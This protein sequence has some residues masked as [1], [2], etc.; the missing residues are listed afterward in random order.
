MNDNKKIAVNSVI[1]FIRL[2]VTTV[3][4]ILASRYVLDALG[5]SDYGLYNVVGGIVVLLNVFNTAM[6]ST[7]YTFI[8]KALGKG[9]ED[10]LN[11]VF[12]TSLVIHL[13][14][15]IIIVVLGLT[16]GNWYIDNYLN[17]PEGKLPD[18][19]FVFYFSIITTSISTLLIPY[20]GLITAHEKF[21]VLAVRDIVMR[22]LYFVAVITILYTDS[23]RIRM[24]AW[25]Q[26]TYNLIYNGS[27][28]IYCKQKFKNQITL[29]I[30]KD[31]S[32]LKEMLS[33]ASWTLVGAVANVAKGQGCSI[34]L[35]FFFGT[36][37][38]A[39]YAVAN[40]I[41]NF[42]LTF[43]RSLNNA[44]IPQ[45]TKSFSGGDQK[46]SITLTSYISK[47][48]F[49]LMSLVAFPVM[50]E[51][52]FLLG[53]WLKEVPEGSSV[54]CKLMVLTGLLNCLGE[55]IPAM[56][57]AT[58]KIRGYQLVVNTILL[59]GLPIGYLAYKL[60]ADYYAISVVYCIIFGFIGFVKLYMLHRVVDFN[61]KDF[62]QISYSKILY[63]SIPLIVAYIFYNSSAF[64]I[65][66]HILGL[67][68]SELFLMIDIAI[69]GLDSKERNIVLSFF[70]KKFN[71]I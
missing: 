15:A 8:A 11:V 64:S 4:G 59:S 39:A 67:I 60:G 50:M 61:V 35:N 55:G 18:A 41:E 34:V 31:T 1:I 10:R 43:A 58:G 5:A 12:N 29:K 13:C 23:S 28:F 14:F 40:Q 66:G 48:T 22:V 37:V 21:G 52:D 53:L 16:V 44:A 6:V 57:N 47:Y 42:I 20:Q 69:L 30:T 2:V 46:R 49:L 51:M 25:I 9:E 65:W 71:R 63:V 26:L 27:F 33:F 24:Y 45:I 62:F 7:T 17:V 19:H 70:K 68:L 38:N 56:V 3:L 54:F 32:L 36:L